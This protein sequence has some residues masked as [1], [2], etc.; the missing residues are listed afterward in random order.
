MKNKGIIAVISALLIGVFVY[1]AFSKLLNYPLSVA[2]LHTHPYIG[3]F[4]GLIAWFVP[5]VELIVSAL[6]LFPGS[7]RIGLYGSAGL[8]FIFTAYLALMLLSGRP[9]PCTC[10]GFI[11]TLDWPQ[12]IVFNLALILLSIIGIRLYKG[13]RL[14]YRGSVVKKRPV[15]TV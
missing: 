3:R 7:R 1:A 8:L 10:G 13:A 14:F 9:L 11:S 2:Q 15:R 4:A 6:L 5:A 12:H